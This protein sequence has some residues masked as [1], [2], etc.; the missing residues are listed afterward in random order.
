V[1]EMFGKVRDRIENANE[2]V[3]ALREMRDYMDVMK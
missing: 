1:R 3:L 2:N